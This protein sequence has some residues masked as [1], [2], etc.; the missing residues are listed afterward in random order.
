LNSFL[1]RV[2]KDQAGFLT[3]DDL[4]SDFSRAFADTGDDMPGPETMLSMF[5]RGELGNFSAG[6]GL[7]G[8]APDFTLPTHDGSQ[9]VTLSKSRGKPVILI[10]G[11]FT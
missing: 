4:L 8:E 9:T 7:G 10:F 1:T 2:D 11:S 6:P 5:F 3:S